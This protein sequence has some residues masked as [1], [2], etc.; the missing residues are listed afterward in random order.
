VVNHQWTKG[1]IIL[2]LLTIASMPRLGVAQELPSNSPWAS[3]SSL[4][5][6]EADQAVDQDGMS[7]RL[8]AAETSNAD[9]AA[10]A[11]AAAKPKAKKPPSPYKGVF[12]DNDF[13]YLNDPANTYCY[14]GDSLK[15]MELGNWVFDVGGEYRM[16]YHDEDHLRGSNLTGGSDDFLLY[17]TRAYVNMKYSDWFR[18]YGEAIDAYSSGEKLTPRI[19]EENRFDALNLFADAMLLDGDCGKFWARGGRQELLYGDQR[20]VSPLDWSNTRRTFDGAKL[21]WR[22]DCWDVD[23]FWTEPISQSQHVNDD[24]NFDHPDTSQAFWG[25]YATYKACKDQVFDFYFLRL[26]EHDGAP[27]FGATTFDS[28]TF[29]SRW[30]GKLDWLLVDT[31]GGYQFGDYGASTQSAGYFTGGLGHEWSDACWK[32]L[33]WVYFDWASGDKDP[34]DNVRQT[35]NQLF[36]LAHKYFGFADLVGRQNIQDF[37]VQYTLKPTSKLSTQLWWHVFHLDQA[38]DS[39]YN[40]NGVAIRT[41]ATG[42]AGRNVGQELDLTAL[43]VVN[44]HMDVLMGYSH[45]YAGSFVKATNPGGVSGDVDFFYT[46]YTLRY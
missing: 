13:S 9:L 27:V 12:Y 5:D 14:L 46:Q 16:R 31:E 35:F 30:K 17:R 2:G 1:A 32:P 4:R 43:Y 20:L 41:D 26:S 39:L 24:R 15:Q 23:G 34:T 19:I 8:T 22:G 10:P 21:F 38:R 28:N 37:N 44:P 6:D 45:F 3:N 33:L 25:I 36:P 29:G 42:A 7:A 40:A 11:K 18:F